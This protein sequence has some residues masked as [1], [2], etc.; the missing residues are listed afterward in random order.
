MTPVK[1]DL[2]RTL[3]RAALANVQAIV[4]HD[5]GIQAEKHS[6]TLIQLGMQEETVHKKRKELICTF[7]PHSVT[8]L[9]CPL[10]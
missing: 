5:P 3:G 8:V 9:V 2:D 6:I 7:E 1:V 10:A 4:I